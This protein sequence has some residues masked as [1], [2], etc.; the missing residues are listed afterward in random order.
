MSYAD[1]VNMFKAYIN[2]ENI[3]THQTQANDDDTP[4][5]YHNHI[6]HNSDIYSKC[7][8]LSGV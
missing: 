4:N 5:I 8:V 7:N 6:V 1:E 2:R 3:P